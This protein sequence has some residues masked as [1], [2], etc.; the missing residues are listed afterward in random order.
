[1]VLKK[2]STDDKFNLYVEFTDGQLRKINIKT[3]LLSESPDAIAVKNQIADFKKAYIEDGVA[4]SWKGLN[5]SLDPEIIYEEGEHI[6]RSVA[7]LK[8]E[9][10]LLLRTLHSLVR[11]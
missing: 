5:V 8:K 9:D 11:K 3:F 7:Y 10:N 1:M 6:H 2:I 4:I